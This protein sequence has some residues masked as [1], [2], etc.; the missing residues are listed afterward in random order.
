[1]KQPLR[2]PYKQFFGTLANQIRLDIINKLAKKD[3]NVTNIVS[4]LDYDQSSISHSLSR[5]EECGF[6]TIQK[7]GKERIYSLNKST[8]KPLFSLMNA[9][10]NKY[11]RH[12]VAKHELAKKEKNAKK[13]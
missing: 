4:A 8:I 6:V 10:V 3:S 1:M 7:Q 12:V 13:D 2:Q 11:C 9:H 5:L